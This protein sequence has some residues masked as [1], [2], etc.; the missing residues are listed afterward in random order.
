[1]TPVVLFSGACDDG[2]ARQVR[3]Q[4]R[5]LQESLGATSRSVEDLE[6]AVTELITN[7][8]R[9]GAHLVE[10]RLDSPDPAFCLQVSDDAPGMPVRGEAG[11]RDL[12]G[13]GLQIVADL[14]EAWGT[15]TTESGKTVWA[16]F[17]RS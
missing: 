13:R 8:V 15:M 7:A 3:R 9:A 11:P 2:T 14:S 1:M 12:H 6:L 5:G 10:V 17:A 4:L 16:R